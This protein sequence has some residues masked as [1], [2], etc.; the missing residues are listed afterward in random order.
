MNTQQNPATNGRT[1]SNRTSNQASTDEENLSPAAR[2]SAFRARQKASRT[3][4]AQFAQSLSFELDAFQKDACEALENDHN[5]LV[6]APTGA[7]KTVVAD[8]AIFLAQHHNVKAFYTTPIKALSNQKYHEL[9]DVYGAERVGLLTGDMSLNADADILVMTT[10]VLRNMIYER[11]TKLEALHYV[12]LDEVH[13]LADRMRGQVWEEVII[14]LP[15][16]VR[17]IGLSAT[18]SNVEDFTAWIRSIR[19]DTTLVMSETRPVPLL[20]H[21]LLQ[22]EPSKEPQVFDLYASS[23]G[24]SSDTST[25]SSS[26]DTS[27]ERS[28]L[29]PSLIQALQNL[30]QAARQKAEEKRPSFSA[31]N[32]SS[33][34]GY[35]GRKGRPGRAGRMSGPIRHYT[36]K[37]WAVVDELDFLGMLPAIYFIFSRTGCDQALA[38]CLQADLDLTTE[39]EVREIRRIVNE[40]VDG[41]LT[42]DEKKALHFHQ[43]VASLEL[44]FA[45]HHAGMITLFRHIVEAL[46]ERGL[47]KIV[48][49]TGTLALGINMPARSVVVEKLEKFNG[50]GHVMLTPGEFTQLTGRAGRRGIDTIGHAVVVDHADFSPQA[51]ANLASKRVYPLHSSFTPTFNMA[52]NLLNTHT[53]A[54]TRSTLN[55]SFAQWEANE[56][57]DGLSSQIEAAY[58][59]TRQYEKAM[60]C[61]MG[62][63]AEFM[64]IRMDLSELE[65]R[66]R[67]ILKATIFPSEKARKKAFAALDKKISILRSREMR[68]PCKACPDFE[69]HIRWG[70]RWARQ[71]RELERLEDRL[72]WRTQSVSRRFDKICD[73]LH[74]LNYIEEVGE[75]S[76]VDWDATGQGQEHELDTMNGLHVNESDGQTTISTI[77]ATSYTLTARGELLRQLYSENDLLLAQCILDGIF[78]DIT[79]EECAALVSGFVYEARRDAGSEPAHYPGGAQGTLATKVAQIKSEDTSLRFVCESFDYEPTAQ[80][81]FGLVE[82]MFN[83]VTDKPLSEV[84][85]TSGIGSDSERHSR[86]ALTAGDFVRACKRV[87]D[88][89]QQLAHVARSRED[90][91]LAEV[92][93]R[94]YDLV[95]H[96]IV[97][98]NPLD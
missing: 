86:A 59:T 97:A 43:F 17:I 93:S 98:L 55:K 31:R 80:L 26:R 23:E 41:Q 1:T 67:R 46:F 58:T 66:D 70:H 20:Q 54:Q 95:N 16:S 82:I 94:A 62:D 78:S 56:S 4:T 81:D 13:Y 45:S 61:E 40:M 72:E 53:L 85:R 71:T 22:S 92:A 88:V 12:I 68:H 63:F 2:Y 8:F 77:S 7:G 90:T 49:A 48:F 75:S 60:A 69:Q 87:C 33:R 29:N 52:V 6:A 32:G 18:V 84:L 9:A 83:W 44:G 57:A 37:R 51:V 50:M 24:N 76:S 21:V 91:R 15:Q 42:P 74:T 47:I 25:D 39:A 65:K 36:P 5:V 11:S 64:R 19:G 10:E 73:I 34:G 14:H 38:Q 89:L 96:G 30:D 79:A 28:L 27:R 35:K 3:L